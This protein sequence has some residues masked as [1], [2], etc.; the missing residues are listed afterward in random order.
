[1]VI[2]SR[3]EISFATAILVTILAIVIGVIIVWLISLILFAIL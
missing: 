2:S 3:H 1:V